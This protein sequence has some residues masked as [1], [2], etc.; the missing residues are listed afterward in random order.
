MNILESL[1]GEPGCSSKTI[2]ITRALHQGPPKD[3][4][5]GVSERSGGRP[6][7]MQVIRNGWLRAFMVCVFLG[8]W[9]C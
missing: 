1:G 3:S 7:V 8:V 9:I 4:T 2:T 6:Q 5:T